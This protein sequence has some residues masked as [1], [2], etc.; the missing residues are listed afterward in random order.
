MRD[1][2]S[3][4]FSVYYL[5]AAEQADEKVR[6]VRATMT[7]DHLRT[8]WN[9]AYASPYLR[10]LNNLLRPVKMRYSPRHLYI[11]RPRESTYKEPISA[12][13]YFDGPLSE[14][15]KQTKVILDVPGGGFVAMS[16]RN[17]DDKLIKWAVDTKLPVLALDYRKAPEYPYPYALNECFDAYRAIVASYGQCLGFSGTECPRIT[18][19]GDSAG[20][21]LATAMTLMIISANAHGHY[22]GHDI[23]PLPA[24]LILLYPTLDMNISSW[25]S[26]DQMALI[27]SD[28]VVRQEHAEF[29]RRKSEDLEK[30]YT[31]ATTPKASGDQFNPFETGFK[32]ANEGPKPEELA[33]SS[34]VKASQETV[35]SSKPQRLRTR[36]A[37]SSMISYF[38][39]RILTPEMMRAMIILYVGPYNRPDFKTDYLLSP[40][41]APDNLLSQFPKIYFMT[42]ERDPLVDDTVI[43]AGRLRKVKEAIFKERKELGLEKSTASF[44]EKQHVEVVLIPGISHG[45]IQFSNLFPDSWKHLHRCS[46]W[47]QEIF[48][49]KPT[50]FEA[51]AIIA[52][53]LRGKLQQP[54]ALHHN[55]SIL[56]MNAQKISRPEGDHGDLPSGATTP[57]TSGDE[58]A[59]LMMSSIVATDDPTATSSSSQ[60]RKHKHKRKHHDD[61]ADGEEDPS[62]PTDPKRSAPTDTTTTV[63]S[64]DV[65]TGGSAVAAGVFYKLNAAAGRGRGVFDNSR[66][67]GGSRGRGSRS[68]DRT[69]QLGSEEDLLKRRMNELTM[70]M[71]GG[72]EF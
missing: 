53:Q 19:T 16:P 26:E 35:E 58:D 20:G 1:L 67:G 24:G 10:T 12:W 42:G 64:T 69:S 29:L 28:R 22:P 21:N 30:R 34:D 3:M 4:I 47:I 36:L 25:M 14:L 49:S 2:C 48:S 38:G 70:S 39:D 55:S 7:V 44:K 31:P 59:P 9:K 54:A 6:K 27:R 63:P 8:S 33:A 72:S 56:E 46:G 62:S 61:V 17:H 52:R 50:P 65:E 13:M 15:R 5:I 37:V 11:N 18:V 71:Q 40:A 57:T 60:K 51:P 45:F 43:F 41:V 32:D 23:I 66:D 68:I